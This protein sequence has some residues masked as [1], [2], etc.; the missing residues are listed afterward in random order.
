MG[1]KKAFK[2]A[3]K[4][5]KSNIGENSVLSNVISKPL[6]TIAGSSLGLGLEGPAL[7]A[8][9]TDAK[10][11]AQR[12]V[13]EAEKQQA[14]AE[15]SLS[16]PNAD[17]AA[18]RDQILAIIDRQQN[19]K[20][21]LTPDQIAKNDADAKQ[22]ILQTYGADNAQ[23]PHL[24]DYISN[25]LAGGIHPYEV[26]SL[27]KTTPEY[28][29]IKSKKERDVLNQELLASEDEVFKKAVP[30]LISSYMRA[31]RLGSSGLDSALANARAS[32]AQQRQNSFAGYS[33]EDALASRNA[34]FQQYLRQS[35]PKYQQEFARN[36][37]SNYANFKA[38]YQALNRRYEI[39]DYNR[40]QSDFNRYLADQRRS[41]SRA[42]P[43]QLLGSLAG[44]GIQTLPRLFGK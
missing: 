43:Y 21:Y 40:Q 37:A 14:A 5:I 27:L 12:A 2:K 19:P 1:L 16:D 41:E 15:A 6:A 39:Q 11:T 30:Q 25:Q 34:G 42:L 35:E 17:Q 13:S 10:A 7:G 20:K 38:P 18:I 31:G 33:R 32:L 3:V 26:M 8:A 9:A 24:I 22:I 36:E 29:D 44:A 28:L 23:D 4:K